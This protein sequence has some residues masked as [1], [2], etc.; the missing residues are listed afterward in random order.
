MSTIQNTRVRIAANV[1]SFD[2]PID[3]LRNNYPQFWRGNDVQ[4][5]IGVFDNATLL[6][7][8]NI[9]SVTLDVRKLTNDGKAPAVEVEPLM[10]KTT[11][12]FD[13]TTTSTTWSDGTKQH[14]VLTFT[15]HES[16]LDAGDYWIS[17][18]AETN[19]SPKKVITL[20]AG[21]VRVLENGGGVPYDPPE[22]K[23]LFYTAEQCD[24]TFINND[25][26]SIST[27]LG[28]SDLLVPSQN[29]TKSYVDTA[30]SNVSGILKD[31]ENVG[32]GVGTVFQQKVG[33]SL[34]FKT[35]TAGNNVSLTNNSD[36]IVISST[37]GSG[38]GSFVKIYESI[39]TTTESVSVE[40]TD[41]FNS[42]YTK[43][44]VYF[45][46]GVVLGSGQSSTTLC[47]TVSPSGAVPAYYT[48]GYNG[49]LYWNSNMSSS[50]S[51]I[52]SSTSRS[53]NFSS[54]ANF[55]FQTANMDQ[56]QGVFRV[57]LD[58]IKESSLF[59]ALGRWYRKTELLPYPVP[60]QG[61]FTWYIEED[62]SSIKFYDSNTNNSI[63]AG[64]KMTVYAIL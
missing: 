38:G 2:N 20:S 44:H 23:K 29:A 64:A 57:C 33:T 3:I 40:F 28:T 41:I 7:V 61:M 36:E 5:E 39:P 9:S 63:A 55:M 42:A 16:A 19:T 34:R 14:A 50:S 60:N 51:G 21:I 17:V 10:S 37:G 56:A 8:A 11:T 46:V 47:S 58:V 54:S 4:F 62:V 52:F 43:Y 13:D 15:G 22:P 59:Y 18:W 24:S 26:I 27:S 30:I 1:A 49:C 48:T 31:A 32:A 12:T 45:E 6:S 53:Y 25:K 35:L